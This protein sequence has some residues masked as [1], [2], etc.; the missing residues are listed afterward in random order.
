MSHIKLYRDKEIASYLITMF[1]IINEATHKGE[2][3]IEQG[4]E[5]ILQNDGTVLFEFD[6]RDLKSLKIR[7]LVDFLEN[8]SGS[9]LKLDEEESS[10]FLKCS[11]AAY[12]FETERNKLWDSGLRDAFLQYHEQKFKID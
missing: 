5:R 9:V 7:I 2:G 6:T 1:T 11:H 12:V 4:K 3:E 10:L 8:A